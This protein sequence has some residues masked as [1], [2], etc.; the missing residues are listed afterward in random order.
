MLCYKK[1]KKGQTLKFLNQLVQPFLHID[2]LALKNC[3]VKVVKLLFSE[4]G[5][6]AIPE[7]QIAFW[8]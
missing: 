7:A 6:V 1:T 4:S 8:M 3:V 5:N 2:T